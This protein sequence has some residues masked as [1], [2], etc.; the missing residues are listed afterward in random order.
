MAFEQREIDGA[1]EAELSLRP[2]REPEPPAGGEVGLP[3]DDPPPEDGHQ[4]AVDHEVDLD[5]HGHRRRVAEPQ[6]PGTEGHV[7]RHAPLGTTGE[8]PLE[9]RQIEVE[10][11]PRVVQDELAANN[12]EALDAHLKTA[13][14]PAA[15]ASELRNVVPPGTVRRVL[16][17]VDPEPQPLDPHP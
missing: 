16:K 11:H 15:P 2:T 1:L 7:P 12:H 9:L 3:S 5:A 10:R 14:A 13:P 17:G 6:S 8:A 4:A